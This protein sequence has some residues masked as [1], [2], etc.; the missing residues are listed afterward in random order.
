MNAPI[1]QPP[2]FL[3]GRPKKL[4]IGG[5]WVE[6]ASGKTFNTIN[7]STG[8]VLAEL[9]QGGTE[10]I[11][12]A[13]KA[14]RAAFEG[15]WRK[16]KPHDRQEI[17]LKLAD[18]VDRHFDQFTLLDAL[19]M[20]EPITRRR[21]ARRR[22]LGLIRYYAGMATN[23]HGETVENSAPGGD[24]V[25][26]TLKEPVGVVGAIVPW[27][28]PMV[29]W[30]WKLG[31]VLA[32]GC[33]A[34]YKPSEE[35]SLSA[36]L[37][38]DLLT[39]TGLPEGVVNIV[40]GHGHEAGAALAAHPDVDKIAFTGSVETGQKILQASIGN[41]KRVTLELGGKSP[42]IVFADVDMDLAV[43]GAAMA[44]FG[45]TGQVCSAGT[46]LF[47]EDKIYDE[48]TERVA[49]F[50][51]TLNVGDAL[52]AETQIGP[53]VSQKQLDRVSRYLDI[54]RDEGARVLSGGARLTD[55]GRADGYFIPPT[56]FGDVQDE[57]RIAREEIFGPVVS[58]LRFSD[59]EEVAKRANRTSF[60]LG[61]GVWTRDVGKA[62]YLAKALRA[63]SV[64]INCYQ[65]MDPAMPFGGYKMSG[66][67]RESGTA[68]FD[69]YLNVKSVWIRTA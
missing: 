42:D 8:N 21:N 65:M 63:G 52:E 61:S 4:L 5:K 7:P 44:C 15:P 2:A 68:Q 69:D 29:S 64:W 26:Y 58:T 27:N 60:G 33:T 46:R 31:P 51:R 17:L 16:F 20:G 50:S 38:A 55:E 56:V 57:M 14:A 34:I 19:E 54:G 53:I 1:V 41:L 62:H 28:G 43:P 30:I 66:Y 37:L 23:L 11:D 13:V 59:I 25:T 24:F 36:L 22:V 3:D 12:R 40:T 67:G 49:A 9:A 35:A 47:V 10:D 6:A 32:T 48:F 39:Q 45:N 18:L